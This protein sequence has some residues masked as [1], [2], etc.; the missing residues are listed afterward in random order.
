M[1]YAIIESYNNSTATVRIGGLEHPAR[2][3]DCF[4]LYLDG[5]KMGWRDPTS[6]SSSGEAYIDFDL[7]QTYD[8]RATANGSYSAKVYAVWNGRE[9]NVPISNSSWI[10]IDKG[11][12]SI[13][14]PDP[15]PPTPRAHQMTQIKITDID[16]ASSNGFRISWKC[17]G[18]GNV[19]FKSAT[20]EQEGSRSI[21]HEVYVSERDLDRSGW[22][23]S[24][25]TIY[26][27]GS[28]YKADL[29][30]FGHLP[31]GTVQLIGEWNSNVRYT[32]SSRPFLCLSQYSY[33][34][35]TGRYPATIA[36]STK[37]GGGYD[38]NDPRVA[39]A[40]FGSLSDE[41]TTLVNVFY[42]LEATTGGSLRYGKYSD[43]IPA[44]GDIITA[45][46]YNSLMASA[47][48]CARSVGIWTSFPSR[49]ESGQIIPSNFISK[50]G[51]IANACLE[52]QKSESNR[53]AIEY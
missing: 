52:K 53:R 39:V 24:T 3:Y 14:D 36:Y 41:W 51:D 2:N 10:T 46:M 47:E 35:Y 43:Y 33:T 49:V 1:S 25:D 16:Y 23:Y 5:T 50:L 20:R 11:G 40:S 44:R 28:V 38:W 19:T 13:I 7:T 18:Y 45:W 22:Y 34:N 37:Y 42:Y 48:S 8:G 12:G 4:R 17:N 27:G 6:S 21:L 26:A 30:V 9:Y 32:P 15:D 29:T 31:L